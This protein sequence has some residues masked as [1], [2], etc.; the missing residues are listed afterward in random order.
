MDTPSFL[1]LVQLQETYQKILDYK[2][3]IDEEDIISPTPFLSIEQALDHLEKAKKHE[4]AQLGDVYDYLIQLDNYLKQ[5]ELYKNITLQFFSKLDD[6]TK[7]YVQQS[8][9]YIGIENFTKKLFEDF[10]EGRYIQT[11]VQLSIDLLQ[12]HIKKFTDNY[13]QFQVKENRKKARLFDE[14][15]KYRD[16]VDENATLFDYIKRIVPPSPNLS[17]ERL[18]AIKLGY[19]TQQKKVLRDL[20]DH[21]PNKLARPLHRLKQALSSGRTDL[22]Q[23]ALN[24]LAKVIAP[25]IIKEPINH[26]HLKNKLIDV[27]GTAEPGSRMTMRVNKK[28]PVSIIVGNQ[29]GFIF[30]RVELDFGDNT[31][32]CY[33]KDFDFLPNHKYLL[34]VHLKKNFPFLGLHDPL[35]QKSFDINE[36]ES[37]VK[38]TTC[39]NFMYDF[40]VEDNSGICAF[41]KC[42]GKQFYKPADTQFWV[43]K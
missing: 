26:A 24:K 32:L 35:T 19:K 31:I 22:L 6:Y 15:Q 37:V 39:G 12:Q 5:F 16:E 41:P 20:I 7:K 1:T 34:H 43:E 4:A 30:N 11:G 28:L 2:E 40:S 25:T 38:C 17:K 3:E 33:N 29:G 13:Q 18:A 27:K 10:S 14:L 36:V 23:N 42:K 9:H 21:K 8:I